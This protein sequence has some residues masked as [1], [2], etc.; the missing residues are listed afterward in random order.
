M[1]GFFPLGIKRHD[2]FLNKMAV[3]IA[4]EPVIFGEKRS[5]HW[6]SP[7]NN[8]VYSVA[9]WRTRRRNACLLWPIGI[10]IRWRIRR[11]RRP[12][13]WISRRIAGLVDCHI[14]RGSGD[15]RFEN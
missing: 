6:I 10:L 2:L 12:I 11:W 8:S 7:E 14:L 15:L 9:G 1:P 4:K 5:F 3:R 13:R